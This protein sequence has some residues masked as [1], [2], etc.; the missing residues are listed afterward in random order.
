MGL[1][2]GASA[3]TVGVFLELQPY[4]FVFTTHF[5]PE[6]KRQKKGC[7]LYMSVSF[8]FDKALVPERSPGVEATY[9]YETIR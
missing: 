7:V 6:L 9:F 2:R 4:R 1:T 3:P 8:H 5:L